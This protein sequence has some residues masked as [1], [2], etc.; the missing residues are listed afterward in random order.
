[1]ACGALPAVD[2]QLLHTETWLTH[3]LA[4]LDG[5]THEPLLRRFATWHLL[6]TLRA[7]A[8][9]AWLDERGLDLPRCRQADLDAWHATHPKPRR[10]ALA[11]FLTWAMNSHHMSRLDLPALPRGNSAPLTRRR[12]LKLILRAATDD[13][14]PLRARVT[15]CLTLLYA[16]PITRIMA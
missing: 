3:R 11:A 15:A 1:M 10:R 4:E 2:K 13:Q 9:L 6:P 5:H 12:R 8:F 14:M 16:Q 7:R